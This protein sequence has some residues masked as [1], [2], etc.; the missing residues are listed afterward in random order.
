VLIRQT[1][2]VIGAA[3][4]PY[5]QPGEWQ[6]NLSFRGL[7]SDTHYRLDDHQEER[8]TLGT[9]VINRQH[10]ADASVSYAVSERVSISA[11]VPF[12]SAS[13]SIPSPTTPTPGPRA[14]QDARG[15]GDISI[16]GRY[17]LF[18]TKRHPTW[19]I[20]V[21]TG[22]KM[23]TGEYKAMDTFPGIN[24]QGNEPR[25]VDQS[26]QP[27][28]GGWGLTFEAQGFRRFGRAQI[29]GSGNYLANPRDTNGTPSILVSLGV[30]SPANR[31]RQVNS[32]PDQYL[33]RVGASFVVAKKVAM[34]TAFRV[35]G[36]RRYDLIGKSHG[37]RRPGVSLFVEPGITI[38][39]GTGSV[40]FNVPVAF[41]R[42]RKPDPYTGLQGD[43]TFPRYIFLGTYSWRLGGQKL[44][45]PAAPASPGTAPVAG[46]A[47]TGPGC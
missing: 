1:A 26:V 9:F 17:W 15:I 16:S 21:G 28:D 41:Y 5:A 11:A 10:A 19:N 12:A 45:A 6:V 42:N 14:Q 29:F 24:G 34:T 3:G 2:P 38:S 4:N 33:A 40:S 47:A 30:A 36:Q 7:T 27:G 8:E 31:D 23:P 20:A 22:V 39:T 18:D 32:V 43:A 13:W 44:R 46:S 25:F 35:E 37:F